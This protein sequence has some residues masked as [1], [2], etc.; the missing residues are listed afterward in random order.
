MSFS[1]ETVMDWLRGGVFNRAACIAIVGPE[2]VAKA[3]AALQPQTVAVM[4]APSPEEPKVTP[5]ESRAL[6]LI[7][8]GFKVAPCYPKT[9][10]VHGALVPNPLEMI[11][12]D[13]AQI[14]AWGT[15]EPNANV[16]VY[17]KQERGGLLFLDKDGA[18]SLREKYQR[19]TGKDF[20]KTLLVQS[21]I[22]DGVAK[23]H[24][25]FLHTPKTIALDGNIPESKTNGQF[26]LRVQNQYVCSIGSIH[27][28]TGLPYKIVEDLPVL[29][30]PDDFLEWLQAQIVEEPKTRD[31]IKARGKIGKP[32][33]YSSLISQAGKLWEDGYDSETTIETATRWA[34]ENFDVPAENFDEALVRK[35][36]TAIVRAYPQGDPSRKLGLLLGGVPPGQPVVQ[37]VQV[38]EQEM[39][40]EPVN[41]VESAVNSIDYLPGS[42][43]CSTRLQDIFIEYF[44]D[45][46]WPLALALPALVTAASVVVP[47]GPRQDLVLGDDALTNLYTALIAEVNAGKSQII[48]W[49]CR[50]LGIYEQPIGSHY[51]EGKWGS[52]EQLL[53]SLHKKQSIFSKAVLVNP[54]EWAHLFAK[55]AIPDSSF[56]TVL[57]TSFYK[58]NQVFTLGGSD[59]GKE[60]NLNLA[61]S[62][63]SGIVEQ[64]FETVFG[65]NT[66]GGL[67]DRFLFGRAP[68]GFKWD[69]VPCPIPTRRY[70]SEWDL[71]PVRIDPSV[72]EVTKSWRKENR[73]LGR[74]TEICTRVATIYASL[75]G[76][77]EVTGKDIEPLKALA[78][79]Q[80]G[81]RQIFR[82]NPGQN[83]DAQFANAS[84][85]WVN[86]H[87]AEWTSIAKLKQHLWRMEEKLG[88]QVAVRSLIGLARSGRI[89]LWLPDRGNLP[90]DYRG[91]KPRIGLVKRVM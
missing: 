45:H 84:L 61:M 57:T 18:V 38:V 35:E 91:P 11:S 89:D 22:Q 54:D 44:Q 55:A 87:A 28:D 41:R 69:Y 29:P 48:E 50:A 42:T 26:S 62:F 76:R 68:N 90:T 72:W 17:A 25:Y 73:D 32:N 53:R 21:S 31:A 47:F 2:M 23:G 14:H 15:Q 34:R 46:D 83:P 27:P 81:L 4:D 39:E 75:D 9:K 13:A 80:A 51:F 70:F 60:Y 56:P 5:F 33:R 59:G 86:K 67:Y 19:E 85:A 77:P 64:D 8:R 49:A 52:A 3:E 10:T 30:M 79:Y 82:P 63:I 16:C 88:P 7:E 36:V 78:L 66:L 6:P 71:K 24:W 37:A 74:I 43:L 65:A 20:P 40:T 58:R 12:N 1:Q